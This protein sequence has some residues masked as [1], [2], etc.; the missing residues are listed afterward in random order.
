MS[1]ASSRRTFIL[2]GAALLAPSVP[3][4][5]RILG[6]TGLKVTELGFGCEAVSDSTVFTRALDAGIN[7]FDTARGY[8]RGHMESV[9]GAALRGRRERVVVSTRTYAKNAADCAIDLDASL[10]ALGRDHV[11]IWYLGIRD[12]PA[13]VTDDMLKVQMDGQKAGKFRF[14]GISTHRL[15]AMVDFIIEK[16][17]DVVQ[18]PYSFALG[19]SRDQ[20]KTDVGKLDAALDRLKAAGIG[21]VGMKVMAGGYR[22]KIMGERNAWQ[23]ALRWA[24]RTDRIQTTSVRMTDSDQLA[25]NLSAM[26]AGYSESDARLLAAYSEAIRPYFCRMCGACDGRCPKGVP[27]SDVVRSIMYAEGYGRPDLA[28]ASFAYSV[29]TLAC[30]DCSGCTVVCPNGVNIAERMHR[31]NLMFC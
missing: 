1:D 28:A 12:K 6:K 22:Q 8:Q 25:E 5:H 21:V 4:K 9:L 19:T 13:D 15:S 7:F 16:R 31:A 26:S 10:K 27:V 17:F 11:D 29:G 24:L 18:I 14:R 30:T 20:E 3:L 23:A 2:S